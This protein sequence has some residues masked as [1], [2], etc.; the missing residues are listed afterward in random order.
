MKRRTVDGVLLGVP[1]ASRLLGNSERSLRALIAN[2]VVPFRRLAGRIVFRRS[3]LEKWIENLPG[4]TLK[5]AE[6]NRKARP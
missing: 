6:A 2:G 5:D 4:V 1:E 3:E